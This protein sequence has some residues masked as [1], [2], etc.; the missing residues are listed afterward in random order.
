MPHNSI[1]KF[2]GIALYFYRGFCDYTHFH[3]LIMDL[4]KMRFPLSKYGEYPNIVENC[5]ATMETHFSV[6]SLFGAH[7]FILSNLRRTNKMKKI[8]SLMLIAVL[9]LSCVIGLTACS[10][11]EDKLIGTWEYKISS[12]SNLYASST[13]TFSKSGD[14]YIA[15]LIMGSADGINNFKTEY[16]IEGN[17]IIF[18]FDN[19]NTIQEEYSLSGDTLT[20]DSKKY[21]KK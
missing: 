16:K 6:R 19:G 11:T 15:T 18:T 10:S 5:V 1:N 2:Y 3:L 8:I 17:K 7:L 9:T 20:I 13:Y 4:A 12:G 21:T 14:K